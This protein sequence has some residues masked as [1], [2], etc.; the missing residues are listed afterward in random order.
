MSSNAAAENEMGL[1]QLDLPLQ[2]RRVVDCVGADFSGV[3]GPATSDLLDLDVCESIDHFVVPAAATE[4]LEA[5][6]PD[7]SF[8]SGT[9]RVSKHSGLPVPPARRPALFPLP[10][11]KPR[12]EVPVAESVAH[13]L[14]ACAPGHA[15]LAKH[16][17]DSNG[18][19]QVDIWSRYAVTVQT[20]PKGSVSRCSFKAVEQFVLRRGLFRRCHG[21]SVSG[22]TVIFVMRLANIEMEPTF[23]TGSRPSA[24]AAHF[25]RYAAGFTSTRIIR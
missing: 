13:V 7:P 2:H 6:L 14:C 9:H 25:K 22:P 21:F 4:T 8:Q 12:S 24:N 16:E 20:I 3:R 17:Q 10:G 18:L 19:N 5:L 15:W 11:R 23:L 1:V